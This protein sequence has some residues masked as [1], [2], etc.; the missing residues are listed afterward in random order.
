MPHRLVLPVLQPPPPP[1][2]VGVLLLHPP[3]A[4][5]L[6]CRL[7]REWQPT[8]PTA[9]ITTMSVAEDGGEDLG[10]TL[11]DRCSPRIGPLVIAGVCG[12]EAAALQLA[13]DGTL[14]HCTGVLLGGRALPPLKPLGRLMT[15]RTIKLRLLWEVS[16]SIAW[17]PALGELLGWFCAAGLDVHGAVLE[18]V[19][20]SSTDA[21]GLSPAFVRM[22]R[23]YLAELVAIAMG[24][25][26]RRLFAP[27]FAR[28]KQMGTARE[29][30]GAPAL[31]RNRE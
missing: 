1:T 16:D 6:T 12:A 5:S 14:P 17:A 2:R 20:P 11:P 26:P 19:G 13:F 4:A 15:D 10:A 8:I 30:S 23:V 24:G 18:P 7:A 29:D 9:D 25:Q 22:S 28:G 3:K 27:S 21:R 31:L